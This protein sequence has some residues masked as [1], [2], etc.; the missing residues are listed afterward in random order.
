MQDIIDVHF[1]GIKQ[2]LVNDALTTFYAVREL[3]GL[4]KKPSTSNCSTG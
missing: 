4:K 1:P 2:K 3:P